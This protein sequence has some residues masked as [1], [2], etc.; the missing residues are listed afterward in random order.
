MSDISKPYIRAVLTLLG[1]PGHTQ[2]LFILIPHTEIYTS[3]C[4]DVKLYVFYYS[5]TIR[6]YFHLY[7]T[8][9]C[10]LHF[11]AR[12][13]LLEMVSSGNTLG[14]NS[15]Q[16]CLQSSFSRV[17]FSMQMFVNF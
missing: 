17:T 10:D 6:V 5:N 11:E 2:N 7:V 8:S 4:R 13:S 16:L 9:E 15:L 14:R 12:P 1:A 3:Y